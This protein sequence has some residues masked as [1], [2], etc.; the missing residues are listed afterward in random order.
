MCLSDLLQILCCS[1]F[2][3]KIFPWTPNKCCKF[4]LNWSARLQV[5][6]VFVECAKRE[7][8]KKFFESLIARVSGML[9]GFFFF[10]FGMWFPLSGGH[11]HCKFGAI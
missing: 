6:A 11:L 8:M 9:E 3:V 2:D 5:T 7:K 1:K 4:Q 10:K